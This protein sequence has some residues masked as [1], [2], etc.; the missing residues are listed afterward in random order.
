MPISGFAPQS[1]RAVEARGYAKDRARLLAAF[2]QQ[3][4]PSFSLVYKVDMSPQRRRSWGGKRRSQEHPFI[5][6]ALARFVQ[7]EFVDFR[8]Y[9]SFAS[10]PVIGSLYGVHW[11][12]AIDAL[13]AHEVAHALVGDLGHGGHG[14][15]WQVAYALLRTWL[16]GQ[17]R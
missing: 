13:V 9:A 1:D 12:I 10:D 2:I 3:T 14:G 11:K 8:E 5:S 15:E 4:R 7:R 6:L 16:L 17:P